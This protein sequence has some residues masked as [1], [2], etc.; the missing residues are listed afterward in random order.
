MPGHAV[1]GGVG[2]V[3]A[4]LAEE[5]V[6]RGYEV[7]VIGRKSSA[8]KRPKLARH[9]QSV[10]ARLLLPPKLERRVYE[11]VAADVYYHVAG[12]V[13]GSLEAQRVPHVKLL[14][15]IV[16]V[17]VELGSR[18]VYVS[19]IGAVGTV[20]GATAGTTIAEEERHLDPRVH[21][22]ESNHEI[23]KAEGERL[24]VSASQRLRGRWSIVRPGLVFGPWG[25]HVEWRL[26]YRLSAM[27]IS[28]DSSK[29][30]PHIYSRDLARILADAG[31]GEFDGKWVNAVD[32]LHPRLSDITGIMCR[33]LDRR[34]V[35]LNTWP[36]INALGR[37]APKS[38][39]LRVAYSI[40]RRG[41]VYSSRFLAGR[42]WTPLEEQVK[43]FIEW[44]RSH[45]RA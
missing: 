34:C 15:D 14:D 8:N 27:G 44:A 43:A 38:S 42:E 2:F 18:I 17:A 36:L 10:G 39:P 37:V 30:I 41:Y 16:R 32:D 40:M 20:R 1:V 23:T 28:L 6:G 24:L 31:E 33:E 25:Y 4:N 13:S 22:Q 29:R 5:L 45:G 9:L 11:R 35:R 19:S 7:T 3:G 21:V 12:A 26:S